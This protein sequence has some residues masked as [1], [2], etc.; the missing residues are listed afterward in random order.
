M[1]HGKQSKVRFGQ[2]NLDLK[3]HKNNYFWPLNE[4]FPLFILLSKDLNNPI[5]SPQSYHLELIVIFCIMKREH[6]LCM[7][8]MTIV[9]DGS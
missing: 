9:V 2:Y 8:Q 6:N 7:H 3:Y 5:C 4:R 1:L